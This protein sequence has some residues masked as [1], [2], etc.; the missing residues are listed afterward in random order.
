MVEQLDIK[1]PWQSKTVITNLVM[2]MAAFY[3]PVGN[4]IA[5]NPEAFASILGLANTGIRFITVGK[6]KF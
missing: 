1:K 3:P 5:Q 6:I 2:A 4:W